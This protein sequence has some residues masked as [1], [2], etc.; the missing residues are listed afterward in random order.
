MPTSTSP[1]R[2]SKEQPYQPGSPA[3]TNDDPTAVSKTFYQPGANNMAPMDISGQQNA[4]YFS[5]M[6][7]PMNTGGNANG[8]TIFK[9]NAYQISLKSFISRY[10]PTLHQIK[11]MND[12]IILPPHKLEMRHRKDQDK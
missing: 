4:T 11:Q 9:Y 10:I 2:H 8:P 5:K 7:P 1:D 12:N 3:Q 6:Y